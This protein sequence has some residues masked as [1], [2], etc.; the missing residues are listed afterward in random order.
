MENINP[1]CAEGCL[2]G[3]TNL[4]EAGNTSLS[5]F[6]NL[7]GK[8]FLSLKESLSFLIS[9]FPLGPDSSS[10]QVA[11]DMIIFSTKAKGTTLGRCPSIDPCGSCNEL[12]CK[13]QK[14]IPDAYKW[15]LFL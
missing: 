4:T 7:S 5:E 6:T 2:L 13:R 14:T 11:R 10:P 12:K 3:T 15:F 1:T 9:C 8:S